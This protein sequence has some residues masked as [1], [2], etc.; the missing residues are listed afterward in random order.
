MRQNLVY[1]VTIEL[2]NFSTQS[3]KITGNVPNK[4][5]L[6]ILSLEIS[7]KSYVTRGIIYKRQLKTFF[8]SF[9]LQYSSD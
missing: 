1:K 8:L 9:K 2:K 5:W 7:C 6:P 3:N 4:K